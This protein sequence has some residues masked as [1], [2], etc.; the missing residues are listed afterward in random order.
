MEVESFTKQQM[1]DATYKIMK[2]Q[3]KVAVVVEH[4]Q[5]T[6]DTH[7]EQH[8]STM[9]MLDEIHADLSEIQLQLERG[10]AMAAVASLTS[11]SSPP[12]TSRDEECCLLWE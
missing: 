11:T 8:R 6:K 5:S 1:F 3:R 4:R 2:D 10:V 12:V 7:Q 9:E